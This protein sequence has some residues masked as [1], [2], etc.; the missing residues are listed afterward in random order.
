[1]HLYE[2]DCQAG[3]DETSLS[4]QISV[5][6]SGDVWG[7]ADLDND[8]DLDLFGWD[9]S[10]GEGQVWLNDGTGTGWTR[11]PANAELDARP[12]DLEYW[13]LSDGDPQAV[14]LPPSDFTGDGNVDLVECGTEGGQESWCRL[15]HGDGDGTFT[16]GAEFEVDRTINGFGVGDLN[17]DGFSDFFGGLDDDDDAG[18]VWVWYGD[19]SGT[20]PSG[21]GAELFDV[22][23]DIPNDDGDL[24][25]SNEPG[26]GWM[27]PYDADGDGDLDVLVSYMNPNSSLTRVIKVA[28]ND[29]TGGMTLQSGFN[30]VHLFSSFYGTVMELV[31]V[32]VWP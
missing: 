2:S 8:D 31:P 25:D 14:S 18:Q 20:L 10:D 1:M 30:S 16:I 24:D 7:T 26:R 19:V 4:S 32:P 12:F 13:D 23:A 6:S 9:W 3:F 15:H 17:G 22:T 11:I 21:G 27:F 28:I 29:G 5:L